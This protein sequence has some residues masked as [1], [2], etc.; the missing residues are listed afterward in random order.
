[1]KMK[2]KLRANAPDRI[3]NPKAADPASATSWAITLPLDQRVADIERTWG[4]LDLFLTYA[5]DDHRERIARVLARVNDAIDTLD[6]DALKRATASALKGL[7]RIGE[8]IAERGLEP[9]PMRYI[10][11]DGLIVAETSED[12]KRLK[13]HFDGAVRIYA[14]A[15]LTMIVEWFEEKNMTIQAAKDMGGTIAA[16]RERTPTEI[17]LNDAIPY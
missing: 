14:L 15:E 13:H 4:S 11:Q 6:N 16:I 12:A 7:E 9:P 2:T 17:E 5:R 1:M 3:T 8:T 10:A